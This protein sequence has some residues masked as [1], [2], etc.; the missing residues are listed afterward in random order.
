MIK[1]CPMCGRGF[2]TDNVRVKYCSSECRYKFQQQ[3]QFI[4]NR[5]AKKSNLDALNAQA[6]AK[7]LT[8]GQLQAAKYIKMHRLEV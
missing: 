6:R 4:K 5:S 3:K 8:Y 2:E 7:G 1:N